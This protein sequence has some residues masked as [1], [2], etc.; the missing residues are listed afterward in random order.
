[1]IKMMD[2]KPYSYERKGMFLS[3]YVTYE[4]TKVGTVYGLGNVR[5]LVSLANMAFLNGRMVEEAQKLE[6]IAPYCFR[7]QSYHPKDQKCLMPR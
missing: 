3:Y 7:C 5:N 1:M 6:N 2:Y 4:G